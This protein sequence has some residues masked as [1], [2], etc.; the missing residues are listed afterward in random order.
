VLLGTATRSVGRDGDG[1]F[2]IGLG[3]GE[4]LVADEFL[5]A[6][7]RAPRTDDIG[8][9]AVGLL[10]GFWLEVDDSLRVTAVEGGW[11]YTTGQDSLLLSV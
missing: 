5:V 10:P 7:G 3:K 2:E 4:R 6:A 11:L 1:P 8:L 9:E